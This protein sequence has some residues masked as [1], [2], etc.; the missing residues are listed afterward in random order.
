L[1]QVRI[2]LEVGHIVEAYDRQRLFMTLQHRAQAETSDA[3]ETVD[4]YSLGHFSITS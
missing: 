3:T 1:K 2:G 4:G